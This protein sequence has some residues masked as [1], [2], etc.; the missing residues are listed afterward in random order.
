V[1]AH[2][3]HL[4]LRFALS[5]RDVEERLGGRGIVV[6][7]ET[8]RAWV[9]KFGA[10]YAA[11]LRRREARVGRTWHLDEMATRVGG[12]VLLSAPVGRGGRRAA[13]TD[14]DRPMRQLRGGRGA[15][16]GVPRICGRTLAHVVAAV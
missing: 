3:V 7:Y 9:A 4:Y 11:D 2:A 12:G 8:V 13:G 14:H 16:L 1:I 15:P 10:P 5:S 6:S